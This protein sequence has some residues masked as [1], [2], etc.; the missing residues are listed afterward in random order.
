MREE[1]QLCNGET[2]MGESRWK[3]NSGYG[4]VGPVRAQVGERWFH[5]VARYPLDTKPKGCWRSRE[6]LFPEPGLEYHLV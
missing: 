5:S 4:K 1:T 6:A 3:D 2:E